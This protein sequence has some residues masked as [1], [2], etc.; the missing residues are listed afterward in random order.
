MPLITGAKTENTSKDAF[1]YKTSLQNKNEQL[2]S[3]RSMSYGNSNN[4]NTTNNIENSA[5]ISRKIRL[6]KTPRIYIGNKNTIA[7]SYFSTESNG[8]YIDYGGVQM[9]TNLRNYLY[10]GVKVPMFI[11]R[12]KKKVVYH[13]GEGLKGNIKTLL[14]QHNPANMELL[15]RK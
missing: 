14:K 3:I 2:T 13:Y 15:Y 10:T 1:Y 5:D 4:N 8:T 12:V 6:I 9:N 7:S 11:D